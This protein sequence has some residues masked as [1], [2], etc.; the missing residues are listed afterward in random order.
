MSTPNKAQSVF[1]AVGDGATFPAG[2]SDYPDLYISQGPWVTSLMAQYKTAK[3]GG[4]IFAYQ[5]L[6]QTGDPDG[7]GNNGCLVNRSVCQ[8]NGWMMHKPGGAEVANGTFGNRWTINPTAGYSAQAAA[9]AVAKANAATAALG[10]RIDGLFLDDFNWNQWGY[11]SSTGGVGFLEYASKDLAFAALRDNAL[12]AVANALHAAGY[13][14]FVNA[15]GTE[16]QYATY[17]RTAIPYCDGLL[18]EFMVSWPGGGWVPT[19]H[20]EASFGSA[21]LCKAAGKYYLAS[22]GPETAITAAM[23][24]SAWAATAMIQDAKAYG[25]TQASYSNWPAPVDPWTKT[26][27]QP[28][29][30]RTQPSAGVWRR[31]F[32]NGVVY[33]NTTGSSYVAAEGTVPAHDALTTV[34]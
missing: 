27:G 14:C 15:G 26:L 11:D 34:P 17:M 30:D 2:A 6:S 22:S 1:V 5:N 31:A 20:I 3:P 10:F 13:E 24:R 9:N 28:S 12:V 16:G 18:N 7:S 8:A 25:S 33:L 21:D 29:G 32:A 4:K 23:N 19:V